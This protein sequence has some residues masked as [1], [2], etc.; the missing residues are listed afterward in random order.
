MF[1]S[2]PN[3]HLPM[4]QILLEI[5][6]VILLI[7]HELFAD[8]NLLN[9][10][11]ESLLSC[12]EVVGTKDLRYFSYSTSKALTVPHVRTPLSSLTEQALHNHS[13]YFRP[14]V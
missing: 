12:L 1:E 11:H 6:P 13:T 5:Q 10:Q 8:L 4:S 3:T 9:R 7:T 14:H 2:I